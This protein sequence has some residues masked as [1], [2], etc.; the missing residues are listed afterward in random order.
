MRLHH[1]KSLATPYHVSNL[2][3]QWSIRYEPRSQGHRSDGWLN[4][5]HRV[6]ARKLMA[7]KPKKVFKC[8]TIAM[9]IGDGPLSDENFVEVLKKA[10]ASAEQWVGTV[11]VQPRA[12]A[13]PDDA[14]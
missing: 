13:T 12:P 10:I 3:F 4:I 9:E 7:S 2:E 1:F 11:V 8:K 14:M 5:V 6:T